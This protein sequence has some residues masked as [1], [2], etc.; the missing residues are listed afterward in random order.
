MFELLVWKGVWGLAEQP[1][2]PTGDFDCRLM[3][4]GSMATLGLIILFCAQ[5]LR[6]AMCPPFGIR[7]DLG[8]N[9]FD[10]PTLLKSTVFTENITNDSE[11]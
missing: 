6:S 5:C 4:S 1:C 3:V 2:A 8:E 11:G 10:I 7:M 9:Y